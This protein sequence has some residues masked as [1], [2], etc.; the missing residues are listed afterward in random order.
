MRGSP[1]YQATQL[2]KIVTAFGQSKHQAKEIARSSG[3]KDWHEIGQNLGIYS[4]NTANLYRSVWIETLRYGKEAFFIKDIER[5]SGLVIT[6]YLERKIVEGIKLGSFN[7]YCSALEKLTVGLNQLAQEK[8]TATAYSWTAE[9]KAAKDEAKEILDSFVETRA[10]VD[11]ISLIKAVSL[12]SY[13]TIAAAQ[14]SIGARISELDHVRPEQFLEDYQFHILKGKGGKNRIV[15]FRHH[16]IYDQYRQLV[17]NNLNPS[18]DK[19]TFDRHQ[20]RLAIRIAAIESKQHY[21]G[22]H[23]LRWNYAKE[24][25][26]EIQIKGGT[27]EEALVQ[28]SQEMGHSR[29]DITEYYLQ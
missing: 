24:R 6:G 4:Y 29:G 25:F 22:S 18:Y 27:R 20:Y 17:N 9:I 3:A 16:K 23:G 8:G 26:N 21:R 13:Q 12:P 14:Y 15:K 11:P 10:Y 19:F 7:A 28:V 1:I 2:L 5:L